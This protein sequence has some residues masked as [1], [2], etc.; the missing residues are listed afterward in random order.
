[1]TVAA[2]ER[3]TARLL[4]RPP[5]ADD[6]ALYHAHFTQPEIER[7]LRPSPLPPFSAGAVD[8]LVAGDQ[9]HW[10]DHGFGPWL[11]IER[12]TGAFAGRGGLHWT[13]VEEMAMVELAWSV[14]PA[15]HGRGYATEMAEAA[16]ARA[17]EMQIEELVALVLPANAPSRRVAEKVGCERSGE[18]THAGLPHLLFRLRLVI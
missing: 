15:M 12:E 8:E 11:L 4:L 3:Q 16:V 10:S 6:R 18:V 17:S 9:A 7:W 2:G 14:E 1:M 13:T 5:N